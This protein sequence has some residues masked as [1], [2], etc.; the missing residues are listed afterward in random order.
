[1]DDERIENGHSCKKYCIPFYFCNRLE[2]K[3]SDEHKKRNERQNITANKCA[4]TLLNKIYL[5]VTIHIC[6]GS[7]CYHQENR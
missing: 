3:E 5:T 1:M 7:A 6:I 4:I 2:Q